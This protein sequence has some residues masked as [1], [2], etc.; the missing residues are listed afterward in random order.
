VYRRAGRQVVMQRVVTGGRAG[1]SGQVGVSGG[2][3]QS[4]AAAF[5]LETKKARNGGALFSLACGMLVPMAQSTSPDYSRVLV[6]ELA[7]LGCYSHALCANSEHN[8]SHVRRKP[9]DCGVHSLQ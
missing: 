9:S 7:Y 2:M 5:Y 3:I 1:G 8:T 6:S 4:V